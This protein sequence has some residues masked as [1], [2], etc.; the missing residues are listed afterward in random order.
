M[1]LLI[2]DPGGLV[3]SWYER[4]TPE[5]LA[6]AGNIVYIKKTLAVSP[7]VWYN[8]RSFGLN[9]QVAAKQSFNTIG[10]IVDYDITIDFETSPKGGGRIYG[11]KFAT[12]FDE[13]MALFHFGI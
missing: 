10:I 1:K 13:Q 7:L 9:H 3:G 2:S 8:S 11:I 12:D 5:N 6:W 4:V